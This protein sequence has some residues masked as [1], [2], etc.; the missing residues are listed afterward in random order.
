MCPRL[1]VAAFEENP[2]THQIVLRDAAR[3]VLPFSLFIGFFSH[4][5]VA[6]AGFALSALCVWSV[7]R[8]AL[9]PVAVR[10]GR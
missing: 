5:P 1:S 3:I 7:I 2:L 10:S 9:R 6:A 4:G 8:N